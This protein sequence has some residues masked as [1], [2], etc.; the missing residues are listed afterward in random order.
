MEPI[1]PPRMNAVWWVDQQ[2]VLLDHPGNRAL[3]HIDQGG[4]NGS[5]KQWEQHSGYHRGSKAENAFF[6]WK[7]IHSPGR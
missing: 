6:R 3:E 4:L 7:T 2:D 1:L 5:R